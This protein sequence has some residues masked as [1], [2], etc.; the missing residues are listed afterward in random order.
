MK[1]DD[2]S[3]GVV[4]WITIAIG[5]AAVVIGAVVGTVLSVTGGI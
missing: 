3:M 4:L 1:N 2:K 5:I